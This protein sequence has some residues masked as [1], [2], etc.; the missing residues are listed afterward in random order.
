MIRTIVSSMNK[1]VARH[2]FEGHLDG[3]TT[4]TGVIV[5]LNGSKVVNQGYASYKQ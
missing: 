4:V 3:S 5:A 1:K 2:C